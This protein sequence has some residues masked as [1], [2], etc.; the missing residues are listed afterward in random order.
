MS[1]HKRE[2][3]GETDSPIELTY[4]LAEL[5]SAQHRAGLA[6]LVLMVREVT[7]FQRDRFANRFDNGAVLELENLTELGVILRLNREGLAALFDLTYA[8]FEAE[9]STE[10]KIK[11]FDRIEEVEKPDKKGKTKLTRRYYYKTIVPEGA[12]LPAWDTTNDG[13][14]PGIWIKLWRDM[15]WNIIRGVPT[16]RNPY[17][18]RVNGASYSKDVDTTWRDLQ[19]PERAIGQTGQY[20]LG[21][22]STNPENIPIKDKARY[23][24]LLH[25]WVFIAQVY[26]PMTLDKEGKRERSGY[27]LAIPDVANLK[28]FSREFRQVLEYR[29][30]QKLGYLPKEAV[31]DLPEEGALDLLN[32]LQ[33]RV[34]VE[35]GSQKLRRIVLGVELIHAEKVGNSGVKIRSVSY[36]DPI[37]ETIDRYVQLRDLYWCPWFRK[38]RLLNLVRSQPESLELDAPL[39]ELPAWYE[40]DA[41]LSRVPRKWL[42]KEKDKKEKNNY[43]IHDARK[44]F[45]EEVKVNT[46]TEIREY[47]E[48]VYKVCQHYVLRKLDSKFDLSWKDCQGNSK[49]EEEYN[50]KKYKVANEAFLAVRSHTEERAFINYFVSTL[51]PFI[52]ETEFADFADNLFNKT[53][54]IRAL[55][56]LA[57]SSQFPLTPKSDN[58]KHKGSDAA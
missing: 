9:R 44:L 10:T 31:I 37:Q 18:G 43:F 20:Y 12:F 34:A 38:Q 53:D 14:N 49:K 30:P 51:Y 40:F 48:I 22:A 8:A 32:L 26:C 58:A 55:T 7:E 39:K 27:V 21:A 52:K 6:G 56:L 4:K 1:K 45:T 16:T 15:M 35:T 24:F 54:E 46:K 47:A 2:T 29:N 36:V 3:K 57:L 23:Q 25:F 50:Q 11:K 28:R 33:N 42:D 13:S 17:N 19:H 41:L 5:P